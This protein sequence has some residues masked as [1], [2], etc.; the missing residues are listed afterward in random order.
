MSYEGYSEHI[1]TEGHYYTRDAYEFNDVCPCG[2][3]SVWENMV[4]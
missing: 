2:A 4:D 1:C 3:E